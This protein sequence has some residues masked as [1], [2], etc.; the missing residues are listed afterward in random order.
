MAEACD[1]ARD[2]ETFLSLSTCLKW[3]PLAKE[4]GVSSKARSPSGF[5]SEYK[6]ANGKKSGLSCWWRNRRSNFCFRHWRQIEENGEPLFETSGK[7][8]GLPTRRALALIMWAWH[9]DPKALERSS[10]LLS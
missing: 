6:R 9:P 10:K 1:F 8:E 3:E 5:L 7:Y 4:R 2:E